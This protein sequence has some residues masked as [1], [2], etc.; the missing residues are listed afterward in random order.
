MEGND[1]DE[2]LRVVEQKLNTHEAVCAERYT[3][4]NNSLESINRTMAKVGWGLLA[5]MALILTRMV[6]GS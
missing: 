6:F 1:M 2:R 4:I 5:G 3:G